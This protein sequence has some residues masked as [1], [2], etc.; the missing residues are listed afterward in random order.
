MRRSQSTRGFSLP[1]LMVVIVIAGIMAAATVPPLMSVLRTNRI[2]AAVN[3]LAISMRSARSKAVSQGNNFVWNYTQATRTY[4]AYDD[5]NNNGTRDAGEI[6]YGP[7]TLPNEVVRV[8]LT[9]PVTITFRSLGNASAG[10]AMEF[11]DGHGAIIRVTLEAPTGM[12]SVSQR[13]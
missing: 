5:D 2:E 3:E 4:Q 9:M 12:V 6:L 11:S 1:E 13:E 10:G 7:A 8:S